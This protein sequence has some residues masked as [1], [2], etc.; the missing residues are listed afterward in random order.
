MILKDYNLS[1][2]KAVSFADFC[3]LKVTFLG[4]PP[5]NFCFRGK[6]IIVDFKKEGVLKKNHAI[7]NEGE[8]W[9][10]RGRNFCPDGH[11]IKNLDRG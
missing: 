4:R 7:Q 2:T 10:W 9:G 6:S 8:R 1:G 5:P 11:L 3:Q